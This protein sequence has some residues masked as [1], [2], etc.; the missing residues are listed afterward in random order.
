[1]PSTG[2]RIG[3]YEVLIVN[4]GPFRSGPETLVHANGPDAHAKM[5]ETHDGKEIVFD[6]NLF[7]LKGPDGIALIDAGTGP[8]FNPNLGRA[9]DEMKQLGITP[10]SVDKVYLTHLH[11]D[12]ARGLL[13]G[14]QAYFPR[15]E[16]YV[17][18]IELAFYTSEDARLALPE[19]RRGS[20]PITRS[21]VGAYQ[22]RIR[23]FVPGQIAPGMMTVSLPGHTMGQT[24][25]I[26]DGDRQRLVFWG[27]GLHMAEIQTADP[28]VSTIFDYDP[29]L[30]ARTRRWMLERAIVENWVVAGSHLTGFSKVGR[31]GDAYQILSV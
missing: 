30:A 19:P 21:I 9:R 6:V 4:D 15:A 14:D 10:A 22:G 20:F 5:L 17:P 2:R 31:R 24:G 11:F 28:D 25:F 1:M 8:G 29:R 26:I 23:P 27:D 13:D 16:I 12:H 3:D 7:V 18:A